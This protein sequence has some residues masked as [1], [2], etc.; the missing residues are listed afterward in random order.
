MEINNTTQKEL[1]TTSPS[2]DTLN[3]NGNTP[4]VIDK[5]QDTLSFTKIGKWLFTRWYFYALLSFSAYRW[6]TSGGI[7]IMI[8]LRIA[9]VLL[10]ML[11]LFLLIQIYKKSKNYVKKKWKK[12]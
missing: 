6:Y 9:D 5:A 12:E 7:P 4:V 2:P 3:L 10:N 8:P 11:I 1:Q